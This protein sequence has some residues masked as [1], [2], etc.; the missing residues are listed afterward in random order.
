MIKWVPMGARVLLVLSMLAA[1]AV[2]AG[3]GQRWI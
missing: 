1:F 2:S 3:A